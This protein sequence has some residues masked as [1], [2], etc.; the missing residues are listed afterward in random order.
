MPKAELSNLRIEWERVR[1]ILIVRLRSIGDTVLSTPS[2]SQIKSLAPHVEIDILLEDWVAPL[3]EDH[4]DVNRVIIAPKSVLGRMALAFRLRKSRYDAVFNFHGGTT[5]AI[6]SLAAGANAVFGYSSYRNSFVYNKKCP[7]SAEFW[8]RST[9]H[10][11]EQQCALVG[12]SGLAIETCPKT[13]LSVSAQSRAFVGDLLTSKL[14]G[15]EPGDFVLIHPAAAYETKRW[16]AKRFAETADFISE[17]GFIPIL[18]VTNAEAGIAD[19]I[20][21]TA[22]HEIPVITNL[23]LRHVAALA[24]EARLFLGNDSGMAH[25]AAAVG[26]PTVVVFGSSNRDHWHPWTDAPW[27]IVYKPFDC[28]PCPGD[29]CRKF[30]EPRCI[31][32]IETSAVVDEISRVLAQS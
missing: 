22:K 6:L 17:S 24:S 7:S 23:P 31:Q 12:Y 21:A 26:T 5:S 25:I 10:S 14:M 8:K 29:E 16:S 4:V 13:C 28:Q 27:G 11:A 2:I 32:E 3:L 30:G 19:E 18:L 15:F 1:R 9:T 20:V